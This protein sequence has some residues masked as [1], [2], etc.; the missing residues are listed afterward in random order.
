M[1][2][3]LTENE[4]TKDEKIIRDYC[5][6]ESYDSE[7]LAQV[8]RFGLDHEELIKLCRDILDNIR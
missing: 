3:T 5:H 6:L 1:N 2:K 4:L 8:L 7:R